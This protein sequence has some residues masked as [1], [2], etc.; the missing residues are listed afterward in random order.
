MIITPNLIFKNNNFLL[1]FY[2][3]LL[4]NFI[5]GIVLYIWGKVNF[6]LTHHYQQR[7]IDLMLYSGNAHQEIGKLT[8]F[9]TIIL[10]SCQVIKITF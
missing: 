9:Q 2:G 5:V 10:R 7:N 8:L 3:E 4:N 1:T 6:Q